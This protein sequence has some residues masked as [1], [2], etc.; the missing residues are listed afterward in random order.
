MQITI[1]FF[2]ANCYA[3]FRRRGK[4]TT[5]RMSSNKA[6]KFRDQLLRKG[7]VEF[8]KRNYK[9]GGWS[10]EYRIKRAPIA[11]LNSI[12]WS[13]KDMTEKWTN[14]V[15]KLT[16]RNR[17]RIDPY[18]VSEYTRLFNAGRYDVIKTTYR[19]QPLP[20]FIICDIE[21]TDKELRGMVTLTLKDWS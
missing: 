5:R 8:E 17:Q 13:T 7:Y 14:G 19:N 9:D 10:W 1:E 12:G 6:I 21:N 20:N 15:W 4:G 11:Y 2:G 16:M 18:T 3:Y